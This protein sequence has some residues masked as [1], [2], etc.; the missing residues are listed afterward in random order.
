MEA[1]V[2]ALVP[3][4]PTA[5]RTK[6]TGQAQGIPLFAVETIRALIDLDL[7]DLRRAP[8]SRLVIERPDA[9]LLIPV[10]PAD[11]C[12]PRHARNPRD[13]GVRLPVSGQRAGRAARRYDQR[14]E[15]RWNRLRDLVAGAPSGERPR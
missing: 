6:I 7:V 14:Q 10:S 8:R 2:D 5:A 11:H 9:A 15:E 3:G 4:M 13:H 1:L 12:R